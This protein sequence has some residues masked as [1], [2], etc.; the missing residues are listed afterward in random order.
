MGKHVQRSPNL[1]VRGHVMAL[2]G[3]WRTFHGPYT[4]SCWGCPVYWA[5]GVAPGPVCGVGE[6]VGSRALFPEC[7]L[8]LQMAV[9][10]RM[11][12]CGLS[13]FLSP[14]PVVFR[15][16]RLSW[17]EATSGG[18]YGAGAGR[19]AGQ[20]A[21]ESSLLQGAWEGKG[22]GP[23]ELSWWPLGAA[24]KPRVTLGSTHIS[25]V[26][27]LRLAGYHL[28]WCCATWTFSVKLLKVAA[29][30]L[31]TTSW[32]KCTL[33][34]EAYL[35]WWLFVLDLNSLSDLAHLSSKYK[36][37]DYLNKLAFELFFLWYEL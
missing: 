6:G 18:W 20:P 37:I 23:G 10:G 1:S 33:R 12:E 11:E 32:Q 28:E 35:T 27:V 36:Y 4:R 17:Q 14:A 22:S 29:N 30:G 16:L 25:G 26:A 21:S 19:R 5:P 7:M 31:W 2:T 34:G 15:V 13:P 24:E 3:G 9:G 8:G